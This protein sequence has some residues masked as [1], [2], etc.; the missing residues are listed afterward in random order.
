M[1]YIKKILQKYKLKLE[2]H[3]IKNYKYLNII[4][5]LILS[6]FNIKTFKR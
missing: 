1:Y 3:F 2:N 6:I 4:Q 5:C